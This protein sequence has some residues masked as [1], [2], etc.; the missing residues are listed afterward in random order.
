MSIYSVESCKDK[1]QSVSNLLTRGHF[2]QNKVS[3][4]LLLSANKCLHI[5]SIHRAVAF[6]VAA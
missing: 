6:K 2:D 4:V 5:E 1:K 3:H